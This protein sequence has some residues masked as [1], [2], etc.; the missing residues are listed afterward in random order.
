MISTVVDSIFKTEL[1]YSVP[2]VCLAKV[3]CV[4][5]DVLATISVL[6]WKDQV[7]KVHMQS[8]FS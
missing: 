2:G 7:K 8:R 6:P 4:I 3:L 5:V 1:V